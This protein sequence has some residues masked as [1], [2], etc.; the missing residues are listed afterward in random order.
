MKFMTLFKKELKE[1]LNA[2][3]IMIM[4]IMVGMLV[5]MGQSM[6]KAIEESAE[7]MMDINLC[8]Q[9]DTEFTQN[10]VKFLSQSMESNGGKVNIIELESDDYPAEL[11][12]LDIKNMV[13]IPEGFYDSVK[14]NESAKVDYVQKI[15]SLG[16]MANINAGSD[17]AV[18]YIEAAV[19][20]VV[21]NTK[22]AGG[23]LSDTEVQFLNKPIDLSY[24]T[25]VNKSSSAVAASIVA[26]LCSTQGMLVPMV[27]YI[28]IMMASNMMINTM[29]TEK[30]DKTLETL[31]SAPISRLSVILAKMLAAGVIA[32]LQAAIYMVGMNKMY[33][34][35]LENLSG[36]EN[37]YDEVLKQLGLTLSTSQYVLVGIQMFLTL[38][39]VL[40]ISLMLGVLA[41][42][43]KSAQTLT[44]PIL[45]VTIIPFIVTMLFDVQ[46]LSPVL[47]YAVYAIP[48]THSFAA[49]QN[50]MFGNTELFTFGLIYQFVFLLI[51]LGL[52]LRIF[53]SDR[54]FT[55]SI[56]GRK[57]KGVKTAE[58]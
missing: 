4:L 20:Q 2:Q 52:A 9:D 22:I 1:M 42:D 12:R 57:S 19:K 41:K 37:S 33:S 32:A 31:L 56:G 26:S 30:I 7:K 6:N 28:L 27:M 23:K 13:I 44:M 50:M 15:T 8:V 16:S 47:R 45:A 21:Y 5:M 35:M 18:K 34:G 48:F 55:M 29:S 25:V 17:T 39:I 53:L 54:I 14:N 38:L 51:C 24:T 58:E 10:V 36:G 46:G 11:K 43:A 3:T 49:S 40:S